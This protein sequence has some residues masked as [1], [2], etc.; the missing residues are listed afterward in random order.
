MSILIQHIKFSFLLYL[1]LGEEVDGPSNG[2]APKQWEIQVNCPD[3]FETGKAIIQV[4]HTAELE[5]KKQL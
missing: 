2:P 4:P 1:P 5:V 3:W